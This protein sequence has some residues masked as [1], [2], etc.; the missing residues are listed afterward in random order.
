MVKGQYNDRNQRYS[1][2]QKKKIILLTN[3]L[4]Y[5]SLALKVHETIHEI[6]RK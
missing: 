3:P 1:V 2:F 6:V 5:D 4:M